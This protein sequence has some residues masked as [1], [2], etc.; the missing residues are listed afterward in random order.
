MTERM[1]AAEYQQ[2]GAPKRNK[3]SAKKV[4]ED[5]HLFDSRAE[6]RHYCSLKLQERQGLIHNLKVHP[7][8]TFTFD[9]RPVTYSSGRHVT[10][11][12]D[13]SYTQD[14][15][16]V[17]Y[18]DVKGLDTAASKIKRA[19]FEAKYYPAKILLVGAP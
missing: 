19:F 11:E 1:S 18:V 6:F 14:G 15:I 13:F 10:I 16:G 2:M 12:L 9:G 8:F 5:G 7:R 17:V 3:Y 4:R